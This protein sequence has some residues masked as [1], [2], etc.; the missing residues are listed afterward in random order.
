LSDRWDYQIRIYLDDAYAEIARSNPADTRLKP[1][2]DIL[3]RHQAKAVSQFDAFAAYVAEAEQQGTGQFPLYKWTKVTIDD[4]EKK[5]KHLGTFA[6]H[7]NGHE[8][9]ANEVADAMEAD[10]QAIAGGGL[11][12]RLSRHDTN[13]ANNLPVPAEFRS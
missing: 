7:V 3:D 1:L 6:L 5:R 12:T 2:T 8:V 4:P 10:L 9:Y 11:V 13:P